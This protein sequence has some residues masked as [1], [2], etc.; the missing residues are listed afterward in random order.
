MDFG[1]WAVAFTKRATGLRYCLL[2]ESLRPRCYVTSSMA[3]GRRGAALAGPLG[4]A[5][6]QWSPY[7]LL[8]L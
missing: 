7:P 6:L 8:D 3:E 1:S 4:P 2:K 5:A